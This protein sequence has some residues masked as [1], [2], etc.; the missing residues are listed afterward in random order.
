[1]RWHRSR[2]PLGVRPPW[3]NR[4]RIS[5][6]SAGRNPLSANS[7]KA[8]D[9]LARKPA[10][11]LHACRQPQGIPRVVGTFGY[12]GARAPRGP[13]PAPYLAAEVGRLDPG[14]SARPS[15]SLS[16]SGTT[17][18]ERRTSNPIASRAGTRLHSSV[19]IMRCL[20]TAHDTQESGPVPPQGPSLRQKSRSPQLFCKRLTQLASR[21]QITTSWHSLRRPGSAESS[22]ISE[23]CVVDGAQVTL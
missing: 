7:E 16:A 17:P 8:R 20:L 6:C 3:V 9:R 13:P 12:E 22:L 23:S 14:R 1:M 4:R 21:R 15:G 11:T 10:G 5:K 2:S 18:V 19:G